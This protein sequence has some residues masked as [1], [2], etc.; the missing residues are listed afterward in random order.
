MPLGLTFTLARKVKLRGI[1]MW[2]PIQSQ[3][4]EWTHSHVFYTQLY[5]SL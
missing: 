4:G 5:L 1:Y 3:P 2:Q